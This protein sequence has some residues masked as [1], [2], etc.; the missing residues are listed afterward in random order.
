[1]FKRRTLFVLGAGASKEVGLP[2]GIELAKI[3]SEKLDIRFERGDQSVGNGD[4]ALFNQ[5]QRAFPSDM[6]SYLRAAHLI[7]DGILLSPSIDSFL[8]L[9]Q[10]K[11]TVVRCGKAAI[12]KS[13]LEAERN[14][15]LYFERTEESSTIDFSGIA[16][17]WLVRFMRM[18][19]QPDLRKVFEQVAFIVFNYDRCLEYFLLH[20]LQRLY[21]IDES[22]AQSICETLTI[23]H[24]YGSMG[25]LSSLGLKGVPFGAS[26]TNKIVEIASGI[27][28]PVPAGIELPGPGLTLKQPTGFISPSP[29]EYLVT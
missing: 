4:L 24:P 17:T 9:H 18:L 29:I 14:S 7:R 19:A 27:I 16:D 21:G 1:M 28:R 26:G 12:A 22:E 2:V 6:G 23:I 20:A 11:Q 8:D 13:I 10:D 5:V 25:G 15:S 3:I